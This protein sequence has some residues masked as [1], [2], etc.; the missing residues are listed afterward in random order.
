VGTRTLGVDPGEKRIGL[1]LSDEDGTI[2]HPYKTID[3]ARSRAAAAEAI[4][5]EAR[6]NEVAAIVV[7]LP[8]RL[9]GTEGVAA[10]RAR[11]LASAIEKA[12]GL[13]VV[14][15]DER[16]TTA[17]ADRVLREAHIRASARRA[18]VDRIAAALLLQ[19][20]ID[21][22]ATSRRETETWSEGDDERVVA[23]P[24]LARDPRGRRGA[25]RARR[26]AR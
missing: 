11:A 24:P 15:W 5:A 6:A 1:A 12:S 20:Y 7:G 23:D 26:R 2:A 25:G 22:L 9:D 8:L 19:S 16:L 21:S 17:A 10:I 13:D 3:G 4:A 14:L 18:V